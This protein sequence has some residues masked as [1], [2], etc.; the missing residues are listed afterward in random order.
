MAGS[1]RAS[2]SDLAG[3]ATRRAP[4]ATHTPGSHSARTPARAATPLHVARSL[5]TIL[6]TISAPLL[7]PRAG[8]VPSRSPNARRGP[9]ATRRPHCAAHSGAQDQCKPRPV[10]RVGLVP[11]SAAAVRGARRAPHAAAAGPGG[12]RRRRQCRGTGR[13]AA[14]AAGPAAAP[15]ASC[16]AA[17]WAQSSSE[18]R[19]A[20]LMAAPRRPHA[21]AHAH[22]PPAAQP[23]TPA[24][25]DPSC[26][27][28]PQAVQQ[29]GQGREGGAL[30]R[31][32]PGGGG[33]GGWLGGA[34]RPGLAAGTTCG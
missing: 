30:T 32:R 7:R 27:A 29:A 19:R 28:T 13:A 2:V 1:T 26:H 4:Y 25:P 11:F 9:Q 31:G 21:S 14:A 20:R 5:W 16:A 6:S 10:Q 33:P 3:A 34:G 17:S 23:P 8:S 24:R 22:G 18:W 12:E 15:A